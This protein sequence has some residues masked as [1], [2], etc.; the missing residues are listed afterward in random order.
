MSLPP[1]SLPPRGWYQDPYEP[2]QDRWWDGAQWTTFTHG[3]RGPRYSIFGPSY[4]RAF[5]AG[6]NRAA[7]RSLLVSRIGV[8]AF[9]VL[10]LVVLFVSRGDSAP[11]GARWVLFVVSVLGFSTCTVALVFGI[12][13]VLRS[14]RLGGLLLAIWGTVLSVLGMVMSAGLLSLFLLVAVNAFSSLHD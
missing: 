11:A 12:Q 6:P 9:I 8:V 7:W 14:R 2:A 10:F 4:A 3:T 1:Q 5:W 13:G